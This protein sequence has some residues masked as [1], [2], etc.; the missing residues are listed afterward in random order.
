MISDPHHESPLVA[1]GAPLRDAGVAVVLVHGRGATADSMLPLAEAVG[2]PDAAYLAPQAAGRTWYPHSFL[3][4]LAANEPH[5][6]SALA[7][8]GRAVERAVA[9]GVPH[10]RVV[11]LGF[12]QGACL[13]SEYVARHAARYGGLVALSGGLIGSGEENGA[14]TFAYAGSLEGTPVFAGCSDVDPH[15][16]EERVRETARV[17]G[18]LG[19]AVD[20][21]IYPGM[22]HTVIDDELDAVR[23]LVARVG[24][25]PGGT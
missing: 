8:V 13:A 16:P 3:A 2:R 7:A 4:P 6:S 15:I 5:L 18:A 19:G 21:R 24:Q 23:A 17:L 11:L 1:A 12:S 9:G 25:G 20:A 10:E 14:K 22:G